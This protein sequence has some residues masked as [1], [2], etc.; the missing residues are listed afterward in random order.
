M[1]DLEEKFL[2]KNVPGKYSQWTEYQN[3]EPTRRSIDDDDDDEGEIH[4]AFDTDVLDYNHDTRQINSD[5][6][7]RTQAQHGSNTGVK[8]VLSDY[9]VSKQFEN[10][11]FGQEQFKRNDAFR[12]ATGGCTMQPGEASISIAAGIQHC[13]D[14]KDDRARGEED[15]SSDDSDF[16]DDDEFLQ[17][18]RQTRLLQVKQEQMITYPT[19]GFIT[20]VDSI[21]LFSDFIEEAHSSVYCIFHLYDNSIPCCRLMNEHLE[22]IAKEMDYCRFFRLEACKV[23]ENFDH[24]GFPCILVYQGGK[25]VANLTPITEGMEP[26]LRERFTIEDVESVL[27]SCGICHPRSS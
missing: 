4:H 6:Y 8:G 25:E 7:A 15:S 20:E 9:R 22:R 27:L 3:D 2:K 11:Q 17:S 23:K 21:I 10:L 1:T 19:F 14:D 18:Y 16:L 5:K 13:K 12:R 24:I 26:S